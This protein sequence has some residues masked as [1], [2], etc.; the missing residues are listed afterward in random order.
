MHALVVLAT[1]QHPLDPE[2]VYN[3]RHVRLLATHTGPA[4]A[5]D[6]CRQHCAEN[7]RGFINTE[8]LYAS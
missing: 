2:P 4:P 3:P 5:E 1:C 6:L 8:M 7:E